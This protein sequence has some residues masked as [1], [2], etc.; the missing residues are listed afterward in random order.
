MFH[1][2]SYLKGECENYGID[3]LMTYPSEEDKRNEKMLF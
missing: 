2:L 3:I 1:N